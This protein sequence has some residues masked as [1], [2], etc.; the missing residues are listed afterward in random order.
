MRSHFSEPAYALEHRD[1]I[2]V[3]GHAGLYI[4]ARALPN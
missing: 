4:A 1:R 2:G 3:V